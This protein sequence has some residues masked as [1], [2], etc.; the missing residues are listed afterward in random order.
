M[1][2]VHHYTNINSLECILKN[3][4]LRLNRLD[5]VDDKQEVSLISQ[6]HWAKYLFVSSWSA[7][8][9]ES[10]AMWNKYAGYNGVRI[11]LPKFPFQS[12]QLI[13]KPEM[14]IFS[15]DNTYS[16]IPFE[17]IYNEKW[18]FIIPPIRNDIYG[19]EV[20]YKYSP[21]K[22]IR[23]IVNNDD[24]GVEF[25]C[26]DLATFKNV[27]WDYQKEFR[28][29]F[30]IIPSSPDVIENWRKTGNPEFIYKHLLKCLKNNVDNTLEYFDISLGDVIDNVEV[31]LGPCC[32]KSE[33]S[34]IRK[35]LDKYT[36]NA[37]IKKSVLTGHV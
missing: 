24:G 32:S 37:K 33:V 22:H 4:T 34:K 21:E 16:P 25:N 30:F 28:Y 8:E 1:E 12:N 7:L 15:G 19:R 36:L 3:R 11:S 27:A 2:L 20:V 17:A 6:K 23:P 18:L 29:I 10:E 26:F 35:L 9:N 31:T 13:S 14:N 5:K